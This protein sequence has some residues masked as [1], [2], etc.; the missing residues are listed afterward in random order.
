VPAL[1]RK[2][3]ISCDDNEGV[4]FTTVTV[5]AGIAAASMLSV[6]ATG[7]PKAQPRIVFRAVHLATPKRPPELYS[8]LPSGE[9]RRL[10][11]RGGD[12]PAWSS[13]RRR[14]AY[15]GGG[16]LG[17]EGIWVMNADGSARRR[18]TSRAGDGDP[19]WSP[20]GRRIVYR[21]DNGTNFDLWIVPAAGGKP[22]P[23]LQTPRANEVTP[24][25]SPDGRRIAF[26][27]TRSGEIQIWVLNVRTRQTRQLTRGTASF[28]PDWAPNGRQVAYATGGRIA[29][30]DADRPRPRLLPSGMPRSADSP[31]W[32]PDGRRI[33]FQRGGQVLS[34]R[35]GGGDLRYVT[36][37]AW[38]TNGDP[39]W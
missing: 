33:T 1:C 9:G 31:A 26:E 17:R 15:A 5:I 22:A 25:W 24:D 11:V 34:M 16:I 10:L 4:K 6:A 8:V 20:D 35:A 12:Q 38:G 19:T 29:V 23:L 14:I 30:V 28:S 39:D 32:S 7:T 3:F 2:S 27:T 21:R 37:A 18:L 36:R 13:S